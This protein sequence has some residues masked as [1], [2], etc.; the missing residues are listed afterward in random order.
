MQVYTNSFHGEK[1]LMSIYT[2]PQTK[3]IICG[4]VS[5]SIDSNTAIL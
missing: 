1:H 3:K 5:H 4:N 2:P